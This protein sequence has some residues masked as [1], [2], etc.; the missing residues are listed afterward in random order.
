MQRSTSAVS[1]ATSLPPGGGSPEHFP[2]ILDDT[3]D[4]IPD[5]SDVVSSRSSELPLVYQIRIPPAVLHE[6][7]AKRE[8]AARHNNKTSA[9]GPSVYHVP[10]LAGAAQEGGVRTPPTPPT[11]PFPPPSLTLSTDELS[12]LPSTAVSVG[13]KGWP[14]VVEA[15]ILHWF[16][17]E[18]AGNGMPKGVADLTP[19][20]GVLQISSWRV[21][22]FVNRTEL[23]LELAHEDIAKVECVETID[24]QSIYLFVQARTG[25]SMLTTLVDRNEAK[26]FLGACSAQ[27]VQVKKAFAA[28]GRTAVKKRLSSLLYSAGKVAYCGCSRSH[29]TTP[30][31][32]LAAKRRT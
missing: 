30:C 2:G 32:S 23:L 15:R 6:A 19:E 4:S 27:G 13:K 28:D 17:G 29:Q 22:A 24:Y 25:P 20:R 14:G 18:T 31:F 16:H 1:H 26:A 5:S 3:G 12:E 10:S 21:A 9:D 8:A 11:P 7:L